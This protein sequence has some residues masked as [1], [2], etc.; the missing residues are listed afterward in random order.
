[1]NSSIL[2]LYEASD[3][4]C[5][6]ISKWKVSFQLEVNSRKWLFRISWIECVEFHSA[7]PSSRSLFE[8]V[9]CLKRSLSSSLEPSSLL[10]S[11]LLFFTTLC[12]R[13]TPH[14]F[15]S[16]GLPGG[17]RNSWRSWRVLGVEMREIERRQH[18][19]WHG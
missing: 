3:K 15:L 17:L 18:E 7:L 10:N 12:K 1:M 5:E 9:R 13:K 19:G 4:L 16:R 14:A 2:K 6:W 11:C 8:S